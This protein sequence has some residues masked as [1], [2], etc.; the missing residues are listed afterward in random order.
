MKKFSFIFLSVVFAGFV[1]PI[2]AGSTSSAGRPSTNLTDIYQLRMRL[3]VPAIYN[4]MESQ[5]LR[6]YRPQVFCGELRI[7]YGGEGGDEVEISI[8]ALT[9]LSYKIRNVHVSYKTEITGYPIWSAVGNNKTGVFQKATLVFGIDA[10]PSYNVG[11]DEPD[12]TLILT[13]ALVGKQFGRLGGY[14][15][16]QL[17]CGCH[18]YGHVSPTR[19]LGPDGATDRV[20]DIAAVNG[21]VY[22]KYRGYVVDPPASGD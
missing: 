8:P 2:V 16:G 11:D 6:R 3:R 7:H 10:N 4:N 13:L 15:A 20:I 14:A 17:G 1:M 22:L 21:N 5:G 9:N 12:N 19:V 18:A